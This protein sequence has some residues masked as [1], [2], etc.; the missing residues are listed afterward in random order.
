VVSTWEPPAKERDVCPEH[1]AGIW[2][3]IKEDEDIVL[4]PTLGGKTTL[5]C[6]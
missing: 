1:S 5:K 2:E 3:M 4:E 6:E